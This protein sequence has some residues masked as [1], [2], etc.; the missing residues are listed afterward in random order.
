M[1]DL[2]IIA[3]FQ[4]VVPGEGEVVK[5]IPLPDTVIPHVGWKLAIRD[6]A[7]AH[8]GSDLKTSRHW[9]MNENH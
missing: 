5:T 3:Y 2:E 9:V 4:T 1:S 8:P 6:A 7:P